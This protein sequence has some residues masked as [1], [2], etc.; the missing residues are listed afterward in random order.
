LDNWIPAIHIAPAAKKIS[1]RIGREK[2][3]K[4]S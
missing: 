2:G 4:P 3:L 1:S